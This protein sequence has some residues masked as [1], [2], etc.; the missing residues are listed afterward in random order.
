MSRPA[1]SIHSALDQGHDVT[2][3][4]RILLAAPHLPLIASNLAYNRH[5][6][7]GVRPNG[8]SAAIIPSNRLLI[9]SAPATVHLDAPTF[10]TLPTGTTLATSPPTAAIDPL[11]FPLRFPLSSIA[12]G[13]MGVV[14]VSVGGGG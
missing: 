3:L 1:A 9:R 2:P 13:V 5:T 6:I 11:R 14:V 4:M 7:G 8:N 10:T 12:P